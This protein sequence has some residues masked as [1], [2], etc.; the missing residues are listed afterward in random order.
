MVKLRIHLGDGYTMLEPFIPE[1][2][3]SQL[4][5]WHRT[6]EYD[7][8]RRIRI[9]SG[10]YRDLF[11]IENAEKDGQI[12]QQLFT[13]PGFAYKLANTLSSQGML[14]DYVDDRTKLPT[15]DLD[16]AIEGMRPYQI[17]AVVAAVMSG[18]GIISAPCG[19]GKTHLI[20]A[21]IRAFKRD[22]L[23]YRNTPLSVV[24]AADMD[25]CRKN[26]NDLKAMFK[27]ER[28]IGLV[29]TGEKDFSDDIQV[30]TFDSLHYID[31]AEIGILIVDECH[32]S[33][34][35]KRIDMVLAASKAMRWGVSA[36]PL[37]RFDGGD[38]VTEGMFGP[39]VYQSSYQQGVEDGALVPIEI[40]WLKAPEPIIG[41]DRYH[42]YKRRASK[43]DHGIELNKNL[44][45]MVAD[46]I[47]K[48]PETRQ[49]MTIMPHMQQMNEIRYYAKDV[50]IVH[51]EQSEDAIKEKRFHEL[52]A[53]SK[54]DRQE[55]Y[56]KMA[57]GDIRS[58]LATYVYKQGVNF[59]SL[60]VM[61]CP[62]GGGSAIVAGQL[63][64]RASR[65]GVVGK[66]KA[67][68]VDFIHEWD[69]YDGE[70]GTMAGPLLRD[71]R[72]RRKVYKSLKFNQNVYESIDDLPFIKENK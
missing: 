23:I 3:P 35:E 24:V 27:K 1:F 11:T 33:A 71:D 69:V 25:V 36:T 42:S 8:R 13:M 19:F 51:G 7:E 60:T 17:D 9:T 58:I 6:L 29:M 46:I 44:S 49:V 62:G 65:A 66:D 41:L 34:T 72:A 37:G 2:M 38:M 47:V 68:I 52:Y 4:K 16:K 64:G 28:E 18:G 30:I 14:Y 56:D 55:I 20:K 15:P 70:N 67:Y 10:T 21:I 48:I 22:D 45:K 57:S 61:V 31:P 54:K 43:I 53:V 12:I 5:Y 50:P 59:P 32:M 63:P 26:Y 40:C 39:V